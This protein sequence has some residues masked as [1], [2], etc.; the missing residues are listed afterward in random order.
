MSDGD[1]S[2]PGDYSEWIDPPGGDDALAAARRRLHR[3]G[4]LLDW[5]QIGFLV[6]IPV[7]SVV[8]I[9]IAHHADNRASSARADTHALTRDVSS[10]TDSV[11]RL[12]RNQEDTGRIEAQVAALAEAFRRIAVATSP[13]ER[14]Q[15]IDALNAIPPASSSSSTSTTR[16]AAPP[17]TTPTAAPASSAGN[18]PPPSSSSST[19]S[20]TTTTTRPLLPALTV[21]TLPPLPTRSAGSSSPAWPSPWWPYWPALACLPFLLAVPVA[22]TA[23]RD[24]ERKTMTQPI[25]PAKAAPNAAGRIIR[26]LYMVVIAVA[27]AIP[28][29]TAAFG[30]SAATSAKLVGLAGGITILVT[31]LWNALEGAG[32]IGTVAA[33]PVAPAQL[34]GDDVDRIA[35]AVHAAAPA[36]ADDRSDYT[37]AVEL[38]DAEVDK[39]AD[40]V[41]KRVAAAPSPAKK[42][43]SP[44][45]K[46]A[47]RRR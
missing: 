8:T 16:P 32:I 42:A 34:A 22:L 25:S 9:V 23:G 37:F 35:Q 7:L 31:A 21:P 44:A 47:P 18:P 36:P 10:L 30:F 5:F 3:R 4:A 20:P 1:L 29:A 14:Q 43:P 39:I 26:T 6:L 28:A 24:P 2:E 38:T 13:A 41:A 12:T 46:A 33:S 45:R 11:D 40:A 15:A 19:T 27:V 17:T